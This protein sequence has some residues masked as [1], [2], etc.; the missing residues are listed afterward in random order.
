[1]KKGELLSIV[2]AS[3]SGKS[4]FAAALF[5]ILPNNAITKGELYYRGRKEHDLIGKGIYIPQSSSF[6]DPLMKV[7][8]QIYL[9]DNPLSRKTKNLYPFQC[10]GGMIR[11]AFFDLINENEEAD[12]IIADEPTPGMD[13]ETA[14]ETLAIL[15]KVADGGKSVILITHD[16]DLAINVSDRIAVFQEGEIVDIVKAKD[17]EKG[18]LMH[19]YTKALYDALP[20]N[21][22]MEVE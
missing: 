4:V 10:S 20:Q 19:P 14:I 8:K 5:D 18:E 2:G 15:R 17:F 21:E 12:I 9:S 13:V 1:M 3:G 7:E 22:F 16:I 6:L 11:N